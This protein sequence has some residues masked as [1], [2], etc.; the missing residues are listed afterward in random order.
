MNRSGVVFDGLDLPT[1][2]GQVQTNQIHFFN[3]SQTS[4]EDVFI[5]MTYILW[6]QVTNKGGS[7]KQKTNPTK[8]KPRILPPEKLN[9]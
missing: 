9:E 8:G 1:W 3:P 4:N 7:K 5:T 2:N 6:Q